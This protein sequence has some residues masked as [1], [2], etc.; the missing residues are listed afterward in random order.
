VRLS[1]DGR[2]LAVTT[3]ALTERSLWIDDLTR[4]TRTPVVTK[5]EVWWPIWAPDGRRLLFNWAT[6]GR[7]TL[8]LQPADGSP[9]REMAEAGDLRPSSWSPDGSHFI[10]PGCLVSMADCD[11]WRTTLQGSALTRHPVFNTPAREIAPEISPDGRYLAYEDETTSR[12]EVYLQP[13]PGP[14]PRLQVSVDG[15]QNPAWNRNGREIF[16]L[17][18]GSDG[19][20]MMAVQIDQA[21][22]LVLGRPRLL[23][24]SKGLF[25]G[26]DP[27][28]CYDVAPDGQRFYTVA[29]SALTAPPSPV[30]HI[31]IVQNW[32]EELKAK[33]PRPARQ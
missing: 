21:Q 16:Y 25:G 22:G 6:G 12:P 26:C 23:F 33:V 31:A 13:Y 9:G 15:G 2:R 20:R 14:G 4:G 3:W 17:S 27:V 7:W 10:A 19:V 24:A 1:P 5:D 11:V 8:V 28:R 29:A 30:T 18:E 32:L